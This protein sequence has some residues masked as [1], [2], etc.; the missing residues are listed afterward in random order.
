[1]FE[2]FES[3]TFGPARASIDRRQLDRVR[4]VGEMTSTTGR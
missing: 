2:A 1:M 4:C 3:G